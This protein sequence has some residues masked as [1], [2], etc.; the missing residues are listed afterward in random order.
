M[1][2]TSSL[3]QKTVSGAMWS[4]IQKLSS[5]ILGLVSGIVLARLLTP[6]DYGI[7][8][9]LAIFLAVSR[10]FIDGGFGSA[11]MQ[12]K[13]PTDEDY[14]TILFWNIGFSIF[15]YLVLYALAPAIA[16]FYDLS[17]LTNVLRIQGLVLIINAARIVQRNQ[18][19]KRL[20]LKKVAIINISANIVSLLVTTY[21]AW[22]GW[23]VWA[24]VMQ[25][26]LV[27]LLCTCLYWQTTNWW[28]KL[29][30]STK[31]F[32]EL[33]NFGGF[34]LLSNLFGTLCHYIQDL[35]IGKLYNPSTLG[36]YIKATTTNGYSSTFIS[37]VISQ[38]SYPVL[39]E[40]Q[41]DKH[42]MINILNRFITVIAFVTFPLMLLLLLLAKPIFIILYSE[43]W[44]PCVPYFQL[45]CISGIAICLQNINYYA[46]AAIGKGKILFKW[47]MV[48]R[49]IG[50][51][52]VVGGLW[53]W[54]IYG[55]LIGYIVSM[56]I[57]YLINVGLV[58]RY[59]GY[60]GVQQFIDLLP[61]LLLSGISFG[62]SLLFGYFETLNL[63]L[64]GAFQLI[65]FCSIYLSLSLF[66]KYRVLFLTKEIVESVISNYRKR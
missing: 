45:L 61:I 8:G 41:N 63:Y 44:L 40:V 12:K 14:S 55:M 38:V 32:K 66:F 57:T 18:L 28:P 48:K 34:V 39:A 23:G 25:Q 4:G 24:L 52:L 11:L 51:I 15:I 47:T 58:S 31:S 64:R 22:K 20:E 1:A 46:I 49:V 21:L 36:Y 30:F 42:Q 13:H 16:N 5:L 35:L 7:V 33:F 37:N 19:R 54:E 29:V 56:W 43:R 9:M 50:L 27:A 26:I 53:I 59:I 62:V 6:N 60:S 10:T 65:V 3:K 17:L 2:N